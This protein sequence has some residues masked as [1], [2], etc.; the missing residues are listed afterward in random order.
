MKAKLTP[1]V[2]YGVIA[3]ALLLYTAA[4]WLLLVAPKRA[5]AG[6]LKDEV[7][8][9][10]TAV[11]AARAAAAAATNT[12]DAQPIA[13]A[14]IFRLATAMPAVPDMAGILLE[15]SRI[16]D[17]TGIEFES[18]TPGEAVVSGTF[19]KV[20]ISLAFDGNFYELSDFLFRLRTLVSVRGGELRAAGRLF[21][22]E[23]IAFEES[24]SGFPQIAA[25]LTVDA[26]V[27]GTE[28]PASAATPTTTEQPDPNAAA[29]ATPPAAAP[30]GAEARPLMAKR[31]DPLKAKQAKQ[32][33]MAIG[34][35]VVLVAVGAFQGPKTLKMLK[36]PQPVTS[37][38]QSTP[39]AAAAATPTAA[40]TPATATPG[41]PAPGAAPQVAVLADSDL[42]P[43]ATQNQLLSFEQFQTKDPFAQQVDVAGASGDAASGSTEEGA[44]PAA[45]SPP[46]DG[47]SRSGHRLRSAWVEP[48]GS[49]SERGAAELH[50]ARV[51][52]GDGQEGRAGA[53]RR[54]E[55]LR[56]R[57]RR[58]RRDR[59]V[60]PGR[61][62]G[63]PAGLARPR[64]QVRPHRRRRREL[65][66]RRPDRQAGARQDADTA[67][68]R[69]WQP[70]RTRAPDG[71]GLRAPE[72]H[73]E[74]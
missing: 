26:Y 36:G 14:D 34:L 68:H 23:T 71:E 27:Y 2:L 12:D 48:A 70:V 37:P 54:D 11:D 31:I 42:P 50:G 8:T 73:E 39:A 19:Q 53:C 66:E 47:R 20:P 69:R 58:D 59:G 52:P 10:R 46:A 22:V 28:V 24:P 9:T 63:L 60:V 32:K 56:Q 65:R 4:F 44:A 43:A 6:K 51:Q 55:D 30:T 62:A 67:E 13:V 49:G 57:H 45:A 74:K 72:A 64:R 18:I 7:A 35:G 61:R 15:L 25:G 33:K 41:L 1:R 5:E 17:E 3:G 38:T 40:A 16:A 29:P 21:A